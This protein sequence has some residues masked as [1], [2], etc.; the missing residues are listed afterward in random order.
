MARP[1]LL[2][3]D[4]QRCTWA[5]GELVA[6]LPSDALIVCA[7]RRDVPAALAL[8]PGW[9]RVL[10]RRELTPLSGAEAQEFLALR[11]TA[12]RAR[13]PI[14]SLFGGLPLGLALASN[15][16]KATRGGEFD[17]ESLVSVQHTLAR[18]LR[19]KNLTLTQQLALDVCALAQ[20]TT[21]ELLERVRGML[22]IP[23][24]AGAED[25]FEWLA[26]QTFVDYTHAGVRPHELARFALHAHLR[27]QHR[28]RYASVL[29]ALRELVATDL[30]SSSS[31]G[32]EF[33]ELLFL[34]RNEPAVAPWAASLEATRSVAVGPVAPAE[35]ESVLRLM[36]DVEGEE[37]VALARHWLARGSM[38]F[39][40]AREE[41]LTGL[42]G[43]VELDKESWGS[44][45][46]TRDP[47]S[48]LVREFMTRNPLQAGE[49][50]L[51][52]RWFFDSK[53]YQ[54]PSGRV[55][56]L[57]ARQTQLL[58]TKPGLRYN[59]GV[60]RTPIQWLPLWKTIELPWEIVGHFSIA[61][62]EF[63]L[64]AFRWC[65]RPI[66]DI[67]VRAEQLNGDTSGE[68]PPSIDELR[69]TVRDRVANLARKV[70]LTPRE[71]EIL[72]RL[73]LGHSAEETAR[74]LAIRP[75]TVKFHQENLLRKTG[76]G[77]RVELLRRLL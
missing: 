76:A 7:S 42:I 48:A 51:L 17:L 11:E 26:A 16:A 49:S 50:S 2:V 33:A 54:S 72:E 64:L 29:R 44:Q 20:V 13:G 58:L 10:L 57:S 62:C 3:D 27:Q 35:H 43:Y 6:G 5:L 63:A 74:Q 19:P 37:S 68:G 14:A 61:G 40:A 67:L 65:R 23:A 59:F 73:C 69:L 75:R 55:L 9:A 15:V 36:L 77:S 12:P 66:R 4:F 21:P 41:G 52:F 39:E 71:R 1:V 53:D 45:L 30:E 60:F 25:A 8:D 24:E 18:L 34:S 56:P 38:V 47:V 22:S 31:P 70:R 46:L 32:L 28:R